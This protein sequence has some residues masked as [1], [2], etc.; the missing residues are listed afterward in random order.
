VDR[1]HPPACGDEWDIVALEDDRAVVHWLV[2]TQNAGD[3]VRV[4][5]GGMLV[6]RFAEDGRCAEHRGRYFR[7]ELR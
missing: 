2:I 1:R 5:Y 3:P 6:L 4:Q 7:R